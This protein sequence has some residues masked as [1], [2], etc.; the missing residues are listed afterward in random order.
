MATYH[1]VDE[2]EEWGDGY[3]SQAGIEAR[4]ASKVAQAVNES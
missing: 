4:E 1:S 3:I 2:L